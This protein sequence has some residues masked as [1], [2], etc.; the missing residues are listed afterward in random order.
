MND[1]GV[2]INRRDGQPGHCGGLGIGIA[3]AGVNVD[4]H[5]SFMR[6]GIGSLWCSSCRSFCSLYCSCFVIYGAV[7]TIVRTHTR[8]RWRT[9]R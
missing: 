2:V 3:N 6:V 4:V 8:T 1:C 7:R 5:G 9:H